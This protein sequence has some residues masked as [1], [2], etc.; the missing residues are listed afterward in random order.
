MLHY[1]SLFGVDVVGAFV[2]TIAIIRALHL[3]QDSGISWN[4]S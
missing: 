1:E 2:L 3:R 4:A